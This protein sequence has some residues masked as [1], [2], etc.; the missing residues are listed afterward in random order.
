VGAYVTMKGAIM[1]D[2]YEYM[3]SNRSYEETSET[4]PISAGNITIHKVIYAPSDDYKAPVDR[5]VLV[6]AKLY[7]MRLH[8]NYAKGV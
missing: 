5:K 3:Q 7:N 6:Y 8:H 4:R 2:C 1:L